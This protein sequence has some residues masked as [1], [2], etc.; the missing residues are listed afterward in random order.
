LLHTQ[1][2]SAGKS[3]HFED[4]V[5]NKA[6]IGDSLLHLHNWSL[7][8]QYEANRGEFSMGLGV[9]AHISTMSEEK[10]E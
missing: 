6:I 4:A 5:W 7:E 1:K 10:E 9:G 8:S 3:P 2:T